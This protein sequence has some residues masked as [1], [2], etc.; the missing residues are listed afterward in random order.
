[1]VQLAKV[2]QSGNSQAVRLPKEFR[3]DVDQVEVS[4]E[5]DAII[6]RPVANDQAPWASLRAAIARGMSPDFMEA[7]REQP[8][9]R[10]R[11]DLDAAFP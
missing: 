8:E 1:M 7:G 9:Q 4:R 2:F 3:L 11:P 5:G 10:D 6:L